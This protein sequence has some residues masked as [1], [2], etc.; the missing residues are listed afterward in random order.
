MARTVGP[1]LIY[2]QTT[3]WVRLEGCRVLGFGNAGVRPSRLN[4]TGSASGTVSG[5]RFKDHAEQGKMHLGHKDSGHKKQL[6]TT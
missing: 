6:G 5:I 4:I 1:K 2:T 3:D